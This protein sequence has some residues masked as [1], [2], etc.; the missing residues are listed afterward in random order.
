VSA[1]R[2]SAGWARGLACLALF[3][4]SAPARADA[5]E[6]R[7]GVGRS[8]LP[9]VDQVLVAAPAPAL[10]S[11]A[12]SAGYGVTESQSG[13]G[14]HHRFGGAAALSIAP[15]PQLMAS[16]AFDGRYDLHPKGDDGAVG[17]PRLTLLGTH[18]V[19]PDLQLGAAASLALPGAS[20]PSLELKAA[21]VSLL[22]LASWQIPRGPLLA[23]QAGFRIDQS[24]KAAPNVERLSAADRMALGLS[25]ANAVPLGI[26]LSKHLGAVELAG[27][28]SAELLVGKHAPPLLQSPL[29][30]SI[31]GRVPLLPGLSG[32]LL[33]SLGLSQRPKYNRITPLIP[34]E[35]RAG[36]LIGLRYSPERQAQRAPEP[37]APAPIAAA[38]LVSELRGRLVDPEGAPIALARV[39]VEIRAETHTVRSEA[40]GSFALGDL[41]REPARLS[42]QADG[43]LPANRDVQLDAGTIEL[44]IALERQEVAAQLRG[45]VR[46]FSGRPLPARVSVLPAGASVSADKDG[47]FVLE[48]EPGVY[49]VEIACDGYLTQRRKVTVQDNGVTVLNVELHEVPR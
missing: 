38:P 49:Q 27:E 25:D 36:V 47:R 20:A 33:L 11:I 48:L 1:P 10:I 18:A 22:A 15:I 40:D 23:L 28:L 16:L 24:A 6:T 46:S 17:Q 8:A 44:S 35:P 37:P 41:P 45:L 31:L 4:L 29:R 9:G 7:A 5:P 3:H 21:V 14:A 42:V 13:E 26:A 32:E 2:R 30:A 43:F 19:A 39:T 12:G 34:V